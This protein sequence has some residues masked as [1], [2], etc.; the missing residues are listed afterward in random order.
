[1]SRRENVSEKVRLLEEEMKVLKQEQL[2]EEHFLQEKRVSERKELFLQQENYKRELL[3]EAESKLEQ[4]IQEYKH[5]AMEVR[6]AAQRLEAKKRE[7]VAIL[8]GE[9]E[10]RVDHSM[11]TL[12]DVLGKCSDQQH[13]QRIQQMS[14]RESEVLR[15]KLHRCRQDYDEEKHH[16]MLKEV[17]TF[18]CFVKEMEQ[19]VQKVNK[20]LRDEAQRRLEEEKRQK[21]EKEERER[22]EREAKSVQPTPATPPSSV[23]STTTATGST[24]V[25]SSEGVLAQYLRLQ[26]KK[27]QSEKMTEPFTTATDNKVKTY[28]FNLQ[29]AVNT[30]VN[31]I[32]TH[33]VQHLKDKVE[34]L[35]QLLD[36]QRV[37]VVGV[38]VS[39][40]TH[41][42]AGEFCLNLLAKKF[43][44]QG[45]K[46]VSSHFEAAFPIAA[47]ILGVWS[48]H[49][50]LGDFLLSHFHSVCPILVPLQVPTPPKIGEAEF[51]K[52]M[53]YRS[54][55]NVPEDD[56]SY[57][58]RMS[59]VVRLYAALVQSPGVVWGKANPLGIANGWKWL[60]LVLNTDPLPGVTATVLFDFLEV[61]GHALWKEYRN[62]FEKL[63]C[64]LIKQYLPK[65]E[66]VTSAGQG[67]PTTRLRQFL[68]KC[69]TSG[70]VPEPKGVLPAGLWRG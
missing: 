3:K 28:R 39:I 38:S 14:T 55:N 70:S 21:K 6:H 17:E 42:L 33:S 2:K 69:I 23:V 63:L 41:P 25:S 35:C 47:V 40:K 7:H 44:N 48:R 16:M 13:I 32:S 15:G 20:A 1:M 53:S 56:S 34:R 43:V 65:I 37:E 59:G 5:Q 49:K 46:Q 30:P 22:K 18:N 26:E 10:E 4:R 24:S 19:E 52:L 67:G 9:V 57:L 62:Q 68:D 12:S 29:K 64:V 8:Y 50:N 61:A 58:K 66:A 60:A 54:N 11:S 31:S 36:G 45:E 51:K 27:K